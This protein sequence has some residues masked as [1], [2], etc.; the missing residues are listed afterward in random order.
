LTRCISSLVNG[1][2]A[3]QLRVGSWRRNSFDERE[4]HVVARALPLVDCSLRDPLPNGPLDYCNREKARAEGND[5][6]V[7]PNGRGN[8]GQRK[9]RGE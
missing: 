8:R 6:A 9:E 1:S 3:P 7:A 5:R 2:A 4:S